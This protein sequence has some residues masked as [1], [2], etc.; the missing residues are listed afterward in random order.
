MEE[1]SGQPGDHPASLTGHSGVHLASL[2]GH[3]HA[4]PVSGDLASS[5]GGGQHIYE[6]THSKN[7]VAE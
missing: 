7:K 1:L 4:G 2:A 3:Q 6:N 5:G